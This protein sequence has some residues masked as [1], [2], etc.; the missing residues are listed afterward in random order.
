MNVIITG[1]STGIGRATALEL[2]R[3]KAALALVARREH[4][5]AE[6]EREVRSLGGTAR[7]LSLDLGVKDNVQQMIATAHREL[8]R[9]DVLINNAGFGYFGTVEKMPESVLNEILAV[10]FVAPVL[11]MQAV[12]PIMRS[13]G[14]GH[15]INVS[16][17]A[18][19]R[20]LPLSGAY[21]A[22]KFALNGLSE[23]LRV[24]LKNSGI[25]VSVVYPGGTRTQFFDAVRKGD[26][27][28]DFK[29]L[30]HVQS[31]EQVARAIVRCIHDPRIEVYPYWPGRFVGWVNAV[32]P[33]LVD[34]VLARWL[35]ER[36]PSRG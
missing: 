3:E 26:A 23:S 20:G 29:P 33:S 14:G 2:A 32:A 30:G 19:K 10:N 24:E 21:C 17:V 36:I 34:S 4:L 16:S 12:L 13:Q 31:A 5:L 35:K 28:T 11:A 1:A 18:G 25:R 15:I 9:I 27:R 22:T 6:L 7:A 8:G